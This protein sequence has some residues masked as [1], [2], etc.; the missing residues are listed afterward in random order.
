MSALNRAD[1]VVVT[2]CPP[3]VR[4]MDLRIVRQT[5]NLYPYQKLFFSTFDYGTPIA[6]YPEKTAQIPQLESLRDTDNILSL[7][8]IENP[9]PFLRY[10][11]R[12]KAKVKVMRYPDHHF[13]TPEDFDSIVRRFNAMKGKRKYIFTTEKDAMRL[14]NSREFPESLKSSIFYIP[15]KVRFLETPDGADFITTLHQLLRNKNI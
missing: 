15:I 13:F 14:K 3:D 2:K 5:L 1:V 12:F 8:G 7:T 11:R 10:L 9:R 4:P 6:L